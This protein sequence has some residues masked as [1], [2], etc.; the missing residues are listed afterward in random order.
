MDMLLPTQRHT[1]RSGPAA[2]RVRLT[3]LLFLGLFLEAGGAVAENPHPMDRDPP[4]EITA[5]RVID[6]IEIYPGN[7]F[8]L[9]RSEYDNFLFR[10]AN[11]T[12]IVT[13]KSVIKR[14]LLLGEGDEYDTALVSESIRNLRRLPFLL[15][16]DIHLKTGSE[17]ENI[18]VVSTSD[19]WT[20]AF[21]VSFHRTG[22]RNDLQIGL[23]ES[24]FLGYG[25][26][27]SHDYF[28][29]DDD[30][31]YY[32]AEIGDDRLWG[33]DFSLS[34][35]Y[36]DNP[37]AGQTSVVLGR[38]FY[39][40]Q[41]KW[42]GKIAYSWL[43]RRIDYYISQYL[44]AQ[45]RYNRERSQ[46]ELSLRVGSNRL[47]YHF[48]SKYEY[49]DLRSRGRNVYQGGAD[50]LLPPAAVDSVNHYFGFT[51]RIQQIRYVAF[52]RINR[53]HKPE[54]VNLG[55]DARVSVGRA[56]EP[57]FDH[58]V[59]RYFSWWPQYSFSALS[60]LVIVGVLG[61]QWFAEGNQFQ[62][63]LNWYFNSYLQYHKNQTLA[64]RIHFLS[65]RLADE[66][67]TLYLDED[68]GLRGFPAFSFNGEDRLVINVENRFFSDLEVLSVGIGA[69]AFADIGNIWTRESEP[70]AENTKWSIGAGLRFG[71]SRSS[72]AEVVRIDCAYAPDRKMWEISVGTG[73]YF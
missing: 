70:A 31:D 16:T 58:R 65:S 12:H 23:E 39:S 4:G 47:K 50:S 66:Y 27:M 48:T 19:R 57:R 26:S 72:Q 25:V 42:G 21:G 2:S 20:T 29:L 28:I 55:F 54:D 10:L 9:S 60:S 22:G 45:E 8:D 71:I 1:I 67:F 73:Q 34:L 15:D 32:Q 24:N 46:L 56:Y 62:Q 51:F 38:P 41:Q 13:R 30:R 33:N 6:S 69:V 7:V 5:P 59:Y 53:F 37:R 17:G 64:F 3:G 63:R 36:S 18:M 40:L 14:E 49:L 35:F 61:E 68:H 11:K 52:E 43:N 44:V